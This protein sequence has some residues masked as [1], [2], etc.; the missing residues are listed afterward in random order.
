MRDSRLLNDDYGVFHDSEQESSHQ[1]EA[2]VDEKKLVSDGQ[3]QHCI[4]EVLSRTGSLDC[5]LMV[6][7]SLYY[8]TLRLFANQCSMEE[9]LQM[10]LL[11]LLMMTMMIAGM[12]MLLMIVVRP[13]VN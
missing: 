5:D 12:L 1:E 10:S 7:E 13:H 8:C 4:M 2:K 9:S 3:P 11:L 6:V